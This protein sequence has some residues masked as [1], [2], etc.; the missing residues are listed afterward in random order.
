MM[1]TNFL[2]NVFGHLK[3]LSRLVLSNCLII[4]RFAVK[5]Q[6]EKVSMQKTESKL[7]G[8]NKRTLYLYLLETLKS[9]MGQTR[10]KSQNYSYLREKRKKGASH[11]LSAS[12]Y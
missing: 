8:Q 6:E 3:L 12:M 10:H 7:K 1:V 4:F 9:F 11:Q 2:T 5:N